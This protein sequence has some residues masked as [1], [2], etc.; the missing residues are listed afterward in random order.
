MQSN[1]LT[2]DT[3]EFLHTIQTIYFQASC[4]EGHAM[5]EA[6]KEEGISTL[7]PNTPGRPYWPIGGVDGRWGQADVRGFEAFSGQLVSWASGRINEY[8]GK[9][10]PQ[11]H[12]DSHAEVDPD[13]Y[14]VYD[15]YLRV[16]ISEVQG[17]KSNVSNSE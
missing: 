7:I 13:G 6:G 12:R 16:A 1:S 17:H 11:R 15:N 4:N 3:R 2:I 10:C 9:A 5:A 8:E 14:E